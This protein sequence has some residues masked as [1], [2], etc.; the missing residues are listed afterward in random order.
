MPACPSREVPVTGD[1][2]ITPRRKS[3]SG[4]LAFLPV[5]LSMVL[6]TVA[7]PQA[8]HA[9]ELEDQWQACTRGFVKNE[10]QQILDACNLFIE[11]Y[12]TGADSLALGYAYSRRGLA[13]DNLEQYASAVSDYRRAIELGAVT[14]YSGLGE[15]YMMGQGVPMDVEHAVELFKQGCK[16]DDS[17]SCMYLWA[18]GVD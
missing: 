15:A 18:L 12:S 13:K 8:G 10:S 11:R 14:G 6:M 17:D 7:Y 1:V 2:L 4:A 9:D 3:S 16:L 5:V